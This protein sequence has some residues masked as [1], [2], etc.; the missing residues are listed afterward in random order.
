[1]MSKIGDDM[2]LLM[3]ILS[4]IGLTHL[5]VDGSIFEGLRA[6]IRSTSSRLKVEHLGRIVDCHLCAGTWCGFFMGYVWISKDPVE[7]F[8]CGCAGAFLANFGASVI[9]WLEAATIVN[10]P[11][12]E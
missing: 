7:V 1:M 2:N 10:L 9:N 5:I 12:D 8:A 11:Q 4:T 6:F 3:F